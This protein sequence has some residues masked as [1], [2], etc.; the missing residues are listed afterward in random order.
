MNL[1][2]WSWFKTEWKWLLKKVALFMLLPLAAGYLIATLLHTPEPPKR[3]PPPKREWKKPP[4]RQKEVQAVDV[5][6]D[7]INK[8]IARPVNKLIDKLKKE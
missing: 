2:N 7:K 3:Q 4:G 6:K 8:E 1:I 5:I